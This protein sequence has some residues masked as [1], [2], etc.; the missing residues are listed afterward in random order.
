MFCNGP[1]QWRGSASMGFSKSRVEDEWLGETH[2]STSDSLD[3]HS[4]K[5]EK[6]AS[7]GWELASVQPPDANSQPP[8][9]T[10][11]IFKLASGGWV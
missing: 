10:F 11:L 9:A 2:T 1:I 3:W 5:I 8:D 4:W 6:M 7:G